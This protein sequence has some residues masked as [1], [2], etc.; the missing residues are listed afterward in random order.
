MPVTRRPPPEEGLESTRLR[1]TFLALLVALLFLLLFARLWYLQIMAGERY[2]ELAQGNAVR[3]ISLVA[4]RGEILDADGDVLVAN[5][6]VN[7]VSVEPDEIPDDRRPEVMADLADLLGTTTDDLEARIAGATVSAVRPKPVAVDVPDDVILYIWENQS[8]RYPGVYAERLPRRDYP[9]GSLAAHV[10]GYTGEIGPEE[11]ASVAYEGYRAGEQIGRAGVERSRESA[12]HGTEG[13]RDL[14]VDARGRVVRQLA[15][16]L[17]EPGA[18]LVLTLDADVQEAAERALAEG[19]ALARGTSDTDGERA[20]G[21]FDAPA[22]AVIVMRPDGA[23]VAMASHPTFDPGEFVGGVSSSYYAS[24]L[25]D[26]AH[27]PLLN[28]AVQAAYPPGSVFKPV[29]ASA[30][31]RGGYMTASSRLPCPAVWR[32]NDATYRN[33]ATWHMGSMDL[34]ESLAQSCDTVFYELARRMFRDEVTGGEEVA[35]G[36]DEEILG[37]EARAW[38]LGARTGIDLPGEQEGVVPG[39]A[40]RRRYWER[41]RASTCAQ[42]ETAEGDSRALLEELCSEQGAR[43]RGG[44][45]V[46]LSIGQGDLQVTPLQMATMYAAVANGGTIPRPHVTQEIRHPGGRVDR[47]DAEAIG[48]LPLD[49]EQIGII[50]RGLEA[51]TTVGTASSVFADLPVATAGKTGTAEAGVRQPFSWYA[52]YAPADDPEY[53]VVSVVEEGG[54]GS[55]VSA[56]VVRRVMEHLFA[57]PSTPIAPTTA[58]APTTPGAGEVTG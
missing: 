32:W 45:A 20:G 34:A 25:D 15:E 57:L 36:D 5:Q 37:M 18:D 24:L 2:V 27:R 51:V 19:I 47:I 26:G 52:G 21:T 28:R 53:I 40:W 49:A 29:T 8:T 56:P 12:L 43:W 16:T 39:R 35:G 42:A 50:R 3:T 6:F 9:H 17:P 48:S 55:R 23:V 7:V 31:L 10:L 46:N 30:A 13:L 44:D 38:G 54:G 33:W 4:P 22:G 14:E 41:T 11:L 1:L 58:T